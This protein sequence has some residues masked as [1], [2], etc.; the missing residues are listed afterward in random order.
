MDFFLSFYFFYFLKV[1][2]I[3]AYSIAVSLQSLEGY[4]MQAPFPEMAHCNKTPELVLLEGGL[5]LGRVRCSLPSFPPLSVSHSSLCIE[6]RSLMFQPFVFRIG[7]RL[8]YC[9]F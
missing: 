9:W 4:R 5:Y 1:L 8:W 7:L 2:Q 3:G 6:T